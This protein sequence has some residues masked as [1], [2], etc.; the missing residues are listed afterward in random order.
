MAAPVRG[1]HR[2]GG[3]PDPLDD[4]EAEHGLARP[5]ARPDRRR[6]SSGATRPR[7]TPSSRPRPRPR[8]AHDPRGAGRPAA[9]RT[10]YGHGRMGGLR[11]G[12]SATRQG[13]LKGAAEYFP[14][15]LDGATDETNPGPQ[16]PPAAGP[17]PLP[18]RLGARS[19]ATPNGWPHAARTTAANPGRG[20]LKE[21]RRGRQ[22]VVRRPVRGRTDPIYVPWPTGCSGR[23]PKPTTPFRKPGSEPPAPTAP[24]STTSTVG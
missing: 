14:W 19:T 5:P 16:A 8:R 7:S 2:P 23:S 21:D 18:P 3:D 4:M 15:V 10:P 6:R 9:A 22:A 20:A 1:R 11:P 13:G 24:R 12:R 17:A